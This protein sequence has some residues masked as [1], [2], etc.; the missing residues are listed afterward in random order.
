MDEGEREDWRYGVQRYGEVRAGAVGGKG[1]GGV[2]DEDCRDGHE[3]V[4]AASG[5]EAGRGGGLDGVA[6]RGV[7]EVVCQ[8]EEGVAH[9]A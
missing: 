6:W 8:S 4:A 7:W 5:V 1:D 9:E 3:A 2:D